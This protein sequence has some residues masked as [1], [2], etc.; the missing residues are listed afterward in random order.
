M[1]TK[2]EQEEIIQDAHD[3]IFKQMRWVK[4]PTSAM[5]CLRQKAKSYFA[6]LIQR[7]ENITKKDVAKNLVN[8]FMGDCYHAYAPDY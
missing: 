5:I 6:V 7:G 1:F 2:V 3:K 8:I 4:T